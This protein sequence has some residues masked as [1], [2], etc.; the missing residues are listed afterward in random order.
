MI[1]I[2]M[3]DVVTATAN[4]ANKLPTITGMLLI[5]VVTSVGPENTTF[6]LVVSP[7]IIHVQLTL[8]F[9]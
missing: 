2:T 3:T 1:I 6:E 9:N 8:F 4:M 5:V 7:E